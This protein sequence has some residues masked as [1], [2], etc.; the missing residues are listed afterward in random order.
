MALGHEAD[1]FPFVRALPPETF[2]TNG[3]GM[4]EGFSEIAAHN[5]RKRLSCWTLVA[6]PTSSRAAA[7]NVAVACACAGVAGEV[8]VALGRL[9]AGKSGPPKPRPGTP[10]SRPNTPAD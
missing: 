10:H 8:S 7:A 1:L 3:H 2:A 4:P 9:V 6:D 5:A